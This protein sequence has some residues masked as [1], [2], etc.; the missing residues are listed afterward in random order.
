MITFLH[1]KA[2][3]MKTKKIDREFLLTDDSVN[4]YGFRLLTS[5]YLKEEFIRNPIGYYMHDRSEGVIVKWEDLRVDGDKVYAKPVINMS[6]E[7]GQQT[8]DEIENGFLNGASV[9]HIV[10]LEYSEDP[11]KMLPGQ[12]GPTITKWYHRECSLCDVPGNMNALALYDK[13]GNEIKLA[14]FKLKSSTIQTM[15]QI[16]LTAAQLALIPNL[17][18]D[19]T[20][21]EVTTAL[22]NL[23]AEADKVPQLVQDLAAAT[24]AKKTAEDALVTEKEKNAKDSVTNQ[25]AAALDKKQITVAQQ[26]LFAKQYAGKPDE[27]KE[28]LATMKPFASVIDKTELSD[29]DATELKALSGKTGTEL[30]NEGK[31]ERLKELSASL[32]KVKYKEAFGEEPKEDETK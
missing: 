29:T 16:I 21:D 12:T 20:A 1:R 7:R 6:N 2:T 11:E 24:T 9:G 26:T 15:K 25:L 3:S 5:G 31:L 14:D 32:F 19:S 28:L 30:F 17:K 10:A 23:K 18:A 27:L 8:V 4:C 22:T 13:D